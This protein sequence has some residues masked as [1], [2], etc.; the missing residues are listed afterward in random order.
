M[1]KRILGLAIVTLLWLSSATAQTSEAP[2]RRE[3]LV[4]IETLRSRFLSAEALQ[5]AEVVMRFVELSEDC[6]IVLDPVAIPWAENTE[7]ADVRSPETM[8]RSL[9]L[10]A[11]FAGNTKAQLDSGKVEDM[12][13]PGW[14][15]VIRAY[16]AIQ[17]K[18]DFNI[19][20]IDELVEM[21]EKGT[22]ERYA[23]ILKARR[24]AGPDEPAEI[25]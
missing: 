21:E 12:P 1:T 11:Y 4:A 16:K 17:E 14:I 15:F 6:L 5:A 18:T 13:Y 19:P 3:V 24:D 7:L 8:L 22:L 25:I 10:A 23:R 9:L 2:S 20:S